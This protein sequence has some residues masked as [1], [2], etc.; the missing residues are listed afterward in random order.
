MKLAL[1]IEQGVIAAN[2]VISATVKMITVLAGK[3]RFRTRL[4]GDPE[5]LGIKLFPPFFRC[6][7]DL[8]HMIMSEQI[9]HTK[10]QEF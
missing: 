10:E 2:A 1:R 3:R 6:F 4:A 7:I 5:L 9:K 8:V